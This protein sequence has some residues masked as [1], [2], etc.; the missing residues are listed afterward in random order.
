MQWIQWLL[1]HGKLDTLDSV[2]IP[3]ENRSTDSLG[4]NRFS[5]GRLL[6]QHGVNLRLMAMV[7][8]RC[9]TDPAKMILVAEVRNFEKK[10]FN[11][12]TKIWLYNLSLQVAAAYTSTRYFVK[13][14]RP[15]E[16]FMN[17]FAFNSFTNAIDGCP[18]DET[19]ITSTL[20]TKNGGIQVPH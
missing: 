16:I 15:L 14:M 10:G 9:K 5:I 8:E 20:S 3:N 19:K 4:R 18:H 6:H 11:L 2:R 1:S 12:E 7:R 17:H 13:H